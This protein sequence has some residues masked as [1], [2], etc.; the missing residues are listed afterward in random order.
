MCLVNREFLNIRPANFQPKILK[1]PSG[2]SKWTEIHLKVAPWSITNT[3]AIE[4][5]L[6]KETQL[7]Y[8][9]VFPVEIYQYGYCWSKAYILVFNFWIKAVTMATSHLMTGKHIPYLGLN[10]LISALSFGE[11]FSYFATSWKWYCL[12]FWIGKKSRLFKRFLLYS[13]ICF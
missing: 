11:I 5:E 7:I 10:Y 6:E 12:T 13:V 8:L 1:F 2:K 3:P 9:K 4:R